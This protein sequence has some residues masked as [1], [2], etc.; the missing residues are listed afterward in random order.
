MWRCPKCNENIEDQFDS[1]W[2]CASQ[3]Q[4]D[5]QVVDEPFKRPSPSFGIAS[6]FSPVVI[7]LTIMLAPRSSQENWYGGAVIIIL[8]GGISLIGGLIS[9]FIGILRGEQPIFWSLIGLVLNG[10]PILWLMTGKPK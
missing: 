1:C 5:I 10:A 7:A 8:V 4:P 9:A 3:T 2:K 6:L